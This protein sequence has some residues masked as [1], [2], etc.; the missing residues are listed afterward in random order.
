M[1]LSRHLFVFA[2]LLSFFALPTDAQ[3]LWKISGN[4]LTKPSY[5]L[6]SVH[7]VPSHFIDSIYGLRAVMAEVEQWYGEVVTTDTT[8]NSVTPD[9]TVL[10]LPKD[11]LLKDF[12]TKEEQER[13]NHFN[14]RLTNFEEFEDDVL[15]LYKGD[16]PGRVLNDL[17][18]IHMQMHNIKLVFDSIPKILF[19]TNFELDAIKNGKPVGALD[20]AELHR[21]VVSNG[22]YSNHKPLK[23]Q[24]KNLLSYVD[25]YAE[26]NY[27]SYDLMYRYHS[28]DLNLM[29]NAKTVKEN[30]KNYRKMKELSPQ[31]RNMIWAKKMP[32]I[33]A[34]KSTLFVVGVNHLG[35]PNTEKRGLIQ[36]LR[37][38]GYTVEPVRKD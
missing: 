2:A 6:G 25:H 4:G 34:D 10:E 24:A 36:L 27:T 38:A 3:L 12:Y 29:N 26:I 31:G 35:N 21:K 13:I 9:K 7:L 20:D 11:M 5:M 33:M 32:A 18:L 17:V 23:K 15:C 16:T 8:V 37:K 1:R 22:Y 28:Q 19:D 14:Y 30:N